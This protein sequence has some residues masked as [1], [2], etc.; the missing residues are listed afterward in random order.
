MSIRGYRNVEKDL[1][2]LLGSFTCV[3]N[4]IHMNRY[5][6]RIIPK[7]NKQLKIIIKKQQ[8][9]PNSQRRNEPSLQKQL[10]ALQVCWP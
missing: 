7:K 5:Q 6:D 4:Y 10:S 1:T 8:K 2:R 9:Q 3:L